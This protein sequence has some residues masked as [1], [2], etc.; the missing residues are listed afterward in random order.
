MKKTLFVVAVAAIAMTACT[1]EKNEYVGDNTPKE[2]AFFPVAQ[3]ATRAAVQSATFPNQE[4]FVV[5]YQATPTAGNYFEKTTF[6]K[7][8][9]YWG[10]TSKRYWPLSPATINFFAVTGIA[11]ANTSH[12]EFPATGSSEGTAYIE[13]ATVAYTTSNS[14]G[15]ST[16]SDIMYAVGQESVTQTGNALAFPAK[17]DMTFYHA[18]ALINFQVKAYSTVE[19]GAITINSIKLNG[20]QYTGTLTVTNN[21]SVCKTGSAQIKPTISWSGETAPTGNDRPNVNNVPSTIS[22]DYAPVNDAKAP[23]ET[24]YTSWACMMVIPST[25][26][27]FTIN[28]TCDGHTYDYDYVPAGYSGGTPITTS[29][30]EGYK[31]TYKIT[32]KL[33]EILINPSVQ[34]WDNTDN[35][36]DIQ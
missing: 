21:A 26:T 12:V 22:T 17:V 3:P 32:F 29:L 6:T 5:A 35:T 24:G 27:G 23:G 19:A 1:N 25:F 28:Y 4:M 7:G 16:Q 10:G 14:Y 11:S 18:L 13:S 2:I 9:S 31:Y 15:A 20:A 30:T 34:P 8:E 33:H 36:F